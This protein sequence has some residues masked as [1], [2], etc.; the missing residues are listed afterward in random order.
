MPNAIFLSSYADPALVP[1]D[2]LPQV[3]FLG[4]SNAGKSSLINSITGVKD[5]ARTSATPGRTRL[6]NV[7]DID[8]LF[9]LVDLPG[10]GYAK[11]RHAEREALSALIKGYIQTSPRLRLAVVIVDCRIGPTDSDRDM[12]EWLQAMALPFILVANKADKLPSSEL[13][14]SVADLKRQYPGVPVVVHSA[15]TH[16]GK[17]ELMDTIKTMLKASVTSD[18]WLR[19]R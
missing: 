3:V 13:A 19:S 12:V 6:I 9:H 8:H 10:Y 2:G 5:L 7:F 14:K 4:R 1:H 16:V 18:R 11:L 17:G 15:V